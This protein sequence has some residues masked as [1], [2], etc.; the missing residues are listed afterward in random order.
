MIHNQWV[1]AQPGGLGGIVR[2]YY[3]GRFFRGFHAKDD[4]F[5][6]LSILRVEV[7]GGF[8]QGKDLGL[9]DQ[10]PGDA[11]ALSLAVLLQPEAA[12][13]PEPGGAGVTGAGTRE[14]PP[15]PQQG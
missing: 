14:A 3:Y 6:D 15:G 11:Q 13:D 1:I 10:G 2:H 5:N 12:F 9:D 7:G 8:I 4:L